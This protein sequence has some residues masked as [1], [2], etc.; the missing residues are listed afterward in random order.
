MTKKLINISPSDITYVQ[1]IAKQ[2]SDPRSK[3]GN[4]SKAIRKIIEEHRRQNG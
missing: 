3:N 2:I 1:M 4:F